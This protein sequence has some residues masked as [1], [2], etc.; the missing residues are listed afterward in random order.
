MREFDGAALDW[1]AGIRACWLLFRWKKWEHLEDYGL[2][3]SVVEPL[4]EQFENEEV[5]NRLTKA[6]CRKLVKRLPELEDVGRE[7]RLQY[8]LMYY[9]QIQGEKYREIL[10]R[11]SED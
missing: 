4:L 1:E 8:A 2:E 11:R 10:S 6:Q 5:P 9:D 7:F 3:R